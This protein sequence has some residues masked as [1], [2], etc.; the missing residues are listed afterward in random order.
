MTNAISH[1]PDLTKP[2][3]PRI[4]GRRASKRLRTLQKDLE[5]IKPHLKMYNKPNI[6][7]IIDLNQT[8]A[9]VV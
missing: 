5:E 8:P 1:V 7:L 9:G 4:F 2:W 3:I 6:A